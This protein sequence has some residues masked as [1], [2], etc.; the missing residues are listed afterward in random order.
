MVQAL[1]SLHGAVLL[2][3]V[4]P[5]AGSQPSSVQTSLSLQLIV[6]PAH[7]SFA[8]WSFVVQALPSSQ[9]AVLLVWVQPEVVLQASVVHT[10]LSLQ[11]SGGPPT[12]LP[13]EQASLVVHAL[14]SLHGALLFTCVQPLAGL[15]PSS[16]Q[17]LLSLQLIG[18]PPQLPPVH[19]S[20]DVQ[21]LPSLQGVLSGLWPSVGQDVDVPSQDSGTSH[22]STAGRQTPPVANPSAG[23]LGPVPSQDSATSHTPFALRQTVPVAN[24]SAGQ[25]MLVPVQTSATSQTPLEARHVAPAL[26]ATWVHVFPGVPVIVVHEST[27]HGLSS[28]QSELVEQDDGLIT[29]SDG[30][31]FGFDEGNEHTSIRTPLA[32]PASAVLMQHATSESVVRQ[33]VPWHLFPRWVGASAKGSLSNENAQ[34]DV[35]LTTAAPLHRLGLVSLQV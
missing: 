20:G 21:A 28:S 34:V 4:Q 18:V 24:P 35:Q 19:T 31:E 33:F 7:T 8:Q 3:C 2:V 9:G 29:Q 26:P 22:E 11:L 23:Q 1:P 30:S 32:P 10:S 13:P 27:V 15:Q 25:K 6:V 16:V 17:P 14:P 5:E 12:Q